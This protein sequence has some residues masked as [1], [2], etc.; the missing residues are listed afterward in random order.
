MA[1]NEGCCHSIFWDNLHLKETKGKGKEN[2][3]N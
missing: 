2:S 3:K 1:V